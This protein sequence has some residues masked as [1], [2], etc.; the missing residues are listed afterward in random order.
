MNDWLDEVSLEEVPVLAGR[1]STLGV[2]P[3]TLV[4]DSGGTLQPIRPAIAPPTMLG[5]GG[6]HSASTVVAPAPHLA[7]KPFVQGERIGEGAAGVIHSATQTSLGREVALKTLRK[8]D[9]EGTHGMAL[10]REARVM[11]SLGHPAIPP[12][13]LL[14]RDDKGGPRVAMLRVRGRPWR[15]YV[16]LEGELECPDPTADPLEWHL[17]ILMRI[18]AATHYAHE[19]GILHRDIKLSNA[20]I[21]EDGHAYLLD[22]GL[23]RSLRGDDELGLPLAETEQDVVGTPGYLP[24]ELA[25]AGDV[26][27]RT[28]VYLLGSCL[29]TLLTGKLRHPG[30]TTITRLISAHNGRPPILPD[31][32]PAGLGDIVRRATAL[33]KDDRHASAEELRADIGRFLRQR[34]SHTLLQAAEDALVR[35]EELVQQTNL[36]TGTEADRGIALL[37]GEV[38]FG[39]RQAGREWPHN[40]KI[41][42]G[43]RRLSLARTK[44]ALDVGDIRQAR[45]LLDEV[46]LPPTDLLTRLRKAEAAEKTRIDERRELRHLRARADEFGGH[47]ERAQALLG[48]GAAGGIGYA[49]LGFLDGRLLDVG[50]LTMV[51]VDLAYGAA[52]LGVQMTLFREMPPTDVNVRLLRA[53]WVAFVGPLLLWPFA[54]A[55]Q[56]PF[57][58]SMVLLQLLLFLVGAMTAAVVDF[59]LLPATTAFAV[60]AALSV[61]WPG[62]ALQF[63]G[64]A[65]AAALTGAVAL[66]P[67][68]PEPS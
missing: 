62:A 52:V 27:E 42:S 7:G 55:L 48:L 47:A 40:P 57:A 59:R 19:R 38:A 24:A 23:A 58:A 5:A 65:I 36:P 25:E 46:D 8:E 3:E 17:R 54:L 32:V 50:H 37:M 9:P 13:H 49:A 28:D 41:P 31:T 68:A 16:G 35:V 11:A 18:C 33:K 1:W 67:K 45:R 14:D 21:G 20:M 61:L 12:I 51:G 56:V 60:S 26:D 44:R 39:F 15:S 4:L 64:L 29:H 63:T 30:R 53:L 22:W 2:D 43:M 66:W 34:G 10:E 6:L